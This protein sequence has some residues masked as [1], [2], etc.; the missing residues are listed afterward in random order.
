MMS[1]KVAVLGASPKADRY[2]NK[3]VK[4]LLEYGHEVLPIHP[5]IDKIHDQ[6]CYKNLAAIDQPI[7]TLTLY[8]GEERSNKML[9][10]IVGLQPQRIIMNPGTEND[11]LKK[12]AEK[13]GIEVVKGCTLVMLQTKQF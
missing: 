10:E 7:H 4:M 9:D 8:V 11:F 13:Q 12:E 6:A 5:N 1:Y 2:S 3:A